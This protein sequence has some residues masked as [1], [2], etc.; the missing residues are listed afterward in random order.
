MTSPFSFLLPLV[1]V[2]VG[3]A[4]A[5]VVQSLHQLLRARPRVRW[6]AL[7]LGAALLAVLTVLN[8]WWSF[9]G[10]QTTGAYLSIAGFLPL[11]AELVLLYLLAAASLPEFPNGVPDEGFDLGAFYD[12]NGPYF[13]TVFALFVVA[14][15][16]DM[17]VQDLVLAPGGSLAGIAGFVVQNL[18]GV[19]FFAVLAVVRNRTVH[20]IAIP[21][22]IALVLLDWWGLRLEAPV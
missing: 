5:H 16:A 8:F 15:T 7:P 17:V 4:V 11:L 1:S 22:W 10:F 2:L 13:W 12:A 21:L 18:L 9:Y 14:V 19:V 3:L 20:R 6:D